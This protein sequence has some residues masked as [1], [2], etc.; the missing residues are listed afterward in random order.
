MF[1]LDLQ[2]PMVFIEVDTSADTHAV[3]S[4]RDKLG[5]QIEDTYFIAHLQHEVA[6]ER[7]NVG[8]EWKFEQEIY[9]A[10]QN[11][12]KKVGEAI[13]VHL[14]SIALQAYLAKDVFKVLQKS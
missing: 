12:F 14:S 4:S 13:G 7:A 2:R 1:S 11:L 6:R 5:E 8:R 3:I 10:A 9:G